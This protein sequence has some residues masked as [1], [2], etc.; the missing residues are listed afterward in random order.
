MEF[1]EPEKEKIVADENG[2]LYVHNEGTDSL[3]M[4]SPRDYAGKLK[5]FKGTITELGEYVLCY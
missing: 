3:Y 4:L 2:Q 1:A 5:N